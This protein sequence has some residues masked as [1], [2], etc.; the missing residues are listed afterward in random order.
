MLRQWLSRPEGGDHFLSGTESTPWKDAHTADLIA[1]MPP[2]AQ[3]DRLAQSLR[4]E[5][6]PWY[7]KLCGHRGNPRADPELGEIWEYDSAA[8][9]LT[10]N[11]FCMLL[12]FAIP[13]G[14]VFALYFVTS[15]LA[16]LLIMSAFLLVF[17]FSMMFVAGHRRGSK[18]FGATAAFA[19]VQV[20]FVGGVNI[21]QRR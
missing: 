14:S 12:S 4:D 1:L 19:A 18:I 15:M 9:T 10:G 21:I 16:R 2:T 5:V 8:L 11:V 6:L 3:G 13:T 17:A 7:H 20:V